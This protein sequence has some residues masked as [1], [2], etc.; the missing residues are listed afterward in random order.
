MLRVICL[1]NLNT[2]ESLS[3]SF[4]RCT[5]WS[6]VDLKVCWKWSLRRIE[7]GWRVGGWRYI[8]LRRNTLAVPLCCFSSGTKLAALFDLRN[9]SFTN[10]LANIFFFLPLWSADW[11]CLIFLAVPNPLF[12]SCV[13]TILPIWAVDACIVSPSSICF[14]SF[15]LHPPPSSPKTSQP[16]FRSDSFVWLY[17]LPFAAAFKYNVFLSVYLASFF[18]M[19]PVLARFATYSLSSTSPFSHHTL[20]SLFLTLPPSRR[21]RHLP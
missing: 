16:P 13:G 8:P 20:P 17:V 21:W 9:V 12:E 15:S 18:L 4:S 6:N 1:A 5:R 7:S 2:S 10:L 11:F 14:F 3:V 19:S